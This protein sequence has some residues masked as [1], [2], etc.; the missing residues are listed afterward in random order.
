MVFVSN[1][2]TV[3]DTTTL[4]GLEV[5]AHMLCLKQLKSPNGGISW[6]VSQE[7][8]KNSGAKMIFLPSFAF[9]RYH[10]A[11]FSMHGTQLH[12]YCMQHATD[13]TEFFCLAGGRTS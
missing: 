7:N 3:L 11:N 2:R 8:L 1:Q 6:E 9:E 5:C 13:A 4:D 12:I 10:L